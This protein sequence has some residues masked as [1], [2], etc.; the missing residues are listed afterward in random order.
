MNEELPLR[1]VH[2]PDPIAWWPLAIGWWM[3]LGLALLFAVYLMWRRHKIR[4]ALE[5]KLITMIAAIRD[6]T[7]INDQERLRRLCLLLKRY[8]ITR[9]GRESVAGLTGPE[10]TAWLSKYLAS[11]L[12][13]TKFS[14]LLVDD[15]YSPSTEF[16]N[17]GDLFDH[18]IDRLG[19]LAKASAQIRFTRSAKDA[20]D[21]SNSNP[22]IVSTD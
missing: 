5:S 13:L 22:R 21:K 20:I 15:P 16:V 1:D 14:T 8:A 17:L 7:S 3:L 18:C 9:S 19:L 4:N 2:L 11:D 10:W 6:D 12:F